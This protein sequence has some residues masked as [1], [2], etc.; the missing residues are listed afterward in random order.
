M[1]RGACNR[2]EETGAFPGNTGLPGP[3]RTSEGLVQDA[4]TLA[5]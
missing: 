1:N 3:E 5:S 4:A 2:Y